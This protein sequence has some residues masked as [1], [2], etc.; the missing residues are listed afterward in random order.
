VQDCRAAGADGDGL[1]HGGEAVARNLDVIDAERNSGNGE[2]SFGIA[3]GG[4]GEIG[5]GGAQHDER[6]GDGAMTGIVHDALYLP[7]QSSVDEGRRQ[8]RQQG[9]QDLAQHRRLQRRSSFM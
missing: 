7:K 5:V 2:G 1:L 8:Q 3:F 4:E 6:F 9:Q